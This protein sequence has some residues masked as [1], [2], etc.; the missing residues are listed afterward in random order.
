MKKSLEVFLKFSFVGLNQ[1]KICNNRVVKSWKSVRLHL[2]RMDIFTQANYIILTLQKP[3]SL[4]V[5]W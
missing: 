2:Y 1:E 4:F 5:A 3:E